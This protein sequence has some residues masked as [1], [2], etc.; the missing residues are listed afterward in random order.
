MVLTD[1]FDILCA[2]RHFVR[3]IVLYNPVLSCTEI[4]SIRETGHAAS[5]VLAS[6]ILITCLWG[7]GGSLTDTAFDTITE[8]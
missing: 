4:P 5:L 7:G 2:C 8:Y 1:T 3:C 6:T